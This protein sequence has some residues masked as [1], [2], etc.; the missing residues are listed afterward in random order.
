MDEEL[1]VIKALRRTAQIGSFYD[2]RRETIIGGS[3]LFK[4]ELSENCI[5]T[6][7]IDF[8]KCTI[9]DKFIDN[10]KNLDIDVNLELS[11][12]SEMIPL[13]GPLRILH[14]S[15]NSSKI[16]EW[17]MIY[18]LKTKQE[19]IDYFDKIKEYVS[20]RDIQGNLNATHVI[21][22]IRWGANA[23]AKFKSENKLKKTIWSSNADLKI[24]DWKTKLANFHNENK[25]TI[26]E[27]TL[28]FEADVISKD[29]KSPTNFDQVTNYLEKIPEFL[30]GGKGVQLEFILLPLY[31][32]KDLFMFNVDS[33]INIIDDHSISYL[34]DE[35]ENFLEKKQNLSDLYSEA[36]NS[37]YRYLFSVSDLEKLKKIKSESN[38]KEISFKSKLKNALI[39]IRSGKDSIDSIKTIA[40]ELIE[41]ESSESNEKLIEQMK[42]KL[43]KMKQIK[44]ETGC[45]LY[46][47]DSIENY[48]G[49][50]LFYSINSNEQEEKKLKEICKLMQLFKLIHNDKKFYFCSMDN[51]KLTYSLKIKE[52]CLQFYQD[53]FCLAMD[54]HS[55][56]RDMLN[57]SFAKSTSLDLNLIKPSKVGILNLRCPN[58]GNEFKCSNKYCDRWKCI[59][60]LED[61]EYDFGT[62]LFCKCGGA[63]YLTFSFK[64]SDHYHSKKLVK[65]NTEQDFKE[66]LGKINQ[67]KYNSAGRYGGEWKFNWLRLV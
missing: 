7:D 26:K 14:K 56:K 40:N 10:L 32:I 42:F 20:S 43:N 13:T 50:I 24:F 17:L 49:F 51:K 16:Q 9:S 38:K 8:I 36:S 54:L 61:L 18:E 4:S 67:I 35:M 27:S 19:K 46:S 44:M 21:I 6:T 63:S 2:I 45:E 66:S 59:T 62:Q 33:F 31:K 60:C 25:E 28:N 39:L 65:F 1:K 12:I 47:S 57:W 41:S 30:N 3:N 55:M 48:S 22:G 5:V 64:C 11:I 15:E 53:G 34:E 52:I 58:S 23:I 29:L 37:S